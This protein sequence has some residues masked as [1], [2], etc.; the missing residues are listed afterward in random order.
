[1]HIAM[2]VGRSRRRRLERP[3]LPTYVRTWPGTLPVM[4]SD[5]CLGG[6]ASFHACK[7]IPAAGRP[8]PGHVQWP[9][10]QAPP[11]YVRVDGHDT[12]HTVME[13]AGIYI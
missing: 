7:S 3:T 8:R 9:R 1:M 11:P 4:L 6:P 5:G 10:K 13:T 2:Q 12:I